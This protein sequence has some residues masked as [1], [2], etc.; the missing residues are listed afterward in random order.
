MQSSYNLPID[1]L[2]RF[3]RLA[4]RSIIPLCLL[5]LLHGA[6]LPKFGLLEQGLRVDCLH[7]GLV[8]DDV[9]VRY[10]ARL[11]KPKG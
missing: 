3:S 7:G 2:P 8:C 6:L 9:P 10:C 5:G 1:L 11:P 4:Q